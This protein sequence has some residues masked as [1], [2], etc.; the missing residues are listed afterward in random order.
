MGKEDEKED[1]KDDKKG[2]KEDEKEEEK[3]E[4][5]DEED[6]KEEKASVGK[7]KAGGKEELPSRPKSRPK[8]GDT[9]T[10]NGESGTVLQDDNTASRPFKVQLKSGSKSRYSEK[11]LGGPWDEDE[12]DEK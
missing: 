9:V 10:V 2:K 12:E 1:E 7:G 5:E 11:D 3:E 4:K 8:V 6:E